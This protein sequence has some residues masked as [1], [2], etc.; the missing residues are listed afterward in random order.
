[1]YVEGLM[2]LISGDGR[3]RAHFRQTVTA[4]GRISCQEPNLQNIPIRNEYGRLLRKAF[5]PSDGCILTG[6][7]YSQIE[8]RVLAHLSDD[9]S[10]IEAFRTGA[11]IHR[12]TAARVFE[13]AYDDIT[14]LDR[15]RMYITRNAY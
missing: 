6:A 12:T 7:D 11:D 14:P 13:L 2:P 3:I 1:M 4:T 15:S 9:E 8:L 10:L 5:I